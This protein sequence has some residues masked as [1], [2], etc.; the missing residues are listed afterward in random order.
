MAIRLPIR[1]LEPADRLQIQLLSTALPAGEISCL[2]LYESSSH[3]ISTRDALIGFFLVLSMLFLMI[4]NGVRYPF[5]AAP[6]PAILSDS[7]PQIPEATKK[8]D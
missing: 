6:Q 1:P 2:E 8:N 4:I 5:A 3:T 7:S